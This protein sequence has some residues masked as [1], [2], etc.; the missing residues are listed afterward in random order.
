[1]NCTMLPEQFVNSTK[2]GILWGARDGIEKTLGIFSKH[3]IFNKATA[4]FLIE[5]NFSKTL[6]V[7]LR[8]NYESDMLKTWK[9]ICT[10]KNSVLPVGLRKD[11]ADPQ[12]E[13]TVTLEDQTPYIISNLLYAFS[14][15]PLFDYF[16]ITE[17]AFKNTTM[18]YFI[19]ITSGETPPEDTTT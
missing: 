11:T 18:I 9:D 10:L 14:I 15:D 19:S 7:L 3:K 13:T 1:M 12:Q 17:A 16:Q 2:K 8:E 5:P 4:L 6:K